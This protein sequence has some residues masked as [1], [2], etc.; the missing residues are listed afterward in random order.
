MPP[1][2]IRAGII[3]TNEL[4]IAACDVFLTISDCSGGKGNTSYD[5]GFAA[6]LH[7]KIVFIGER[8]LL[9]HY[10]PWTIHKNT[11][12]EWMLEAIP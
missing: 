4:E 3:V 12:A 2:E 1:P 5:M 10:R 11:L 7:K 6:A 9:A 8:T